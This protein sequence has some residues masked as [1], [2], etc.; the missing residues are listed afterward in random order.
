MGTITRYGSFNSEQTLDILDHRI[1]K[2][3]LTM[4]RQGKILWQKAPPPPGMGK[5]S[6][7]KF[8]V[9]LSSKG[10]KEFSGVISC[11]C[12]FLPFIDYGQRKGAM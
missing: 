1:S 5:I 3:V 7:I 8:R 11:S 12:I 9:R 6:F 2:F 4:E 10:Q